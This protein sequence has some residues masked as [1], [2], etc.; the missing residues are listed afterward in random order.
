M[1][2][3]SLKTTLQLSVMI[4]IILIGF[5]ISQFVIQQYSTALLESAKAKAE[6]IAHKLAIDSADLILINDLVSV[7]KELDGQMLTTPSIVYIF[8][9]KEGEVVAH[10]FK[11]GIPR[12]L[13]QFNT[14]F[15]EVNGRIKPIQSETGEKIFDIAWPIFSGR[16][17]TIRLG[18]SEAPY[19]EKVRELWLKMSLITLVIIVLAL[20]ITHYLMN[21]LTKPLSVLTRKVKQ[22]DEGSLDETIEVKGRREVTRL[23]SAFN[24]MLVRLQ[25]HTRQLNRSN[26]ALLNKNQAL[27]RA[28]KQLSKT[29][30][31]SKEVA[32][33]PKLHDISA[34]LLST[35][36]EIL[37]CQQML[38]LIISPDE[39]LYLLSD[40]EKKIL[41]GEKYYQAVQLLTDLRYYR[42]F[43]TDAFSFLDLPV[44]ISTAAKLTV[45]PLQK[46]GELM[47]VLMVGCRE[48]CDC[49]SEELAVVDPILNQTVGAFHRS[50]RMEEELEQLSKKVEKSNQFH[51]LIGKDS[52]MQA[53]FQL[54][55]NVASTDTSVLVQGESGTGKELVAVA[56]HACSPRK[57]K[58]FTVIN[59]SAYPA[60]LLE[61][62]LF[63]HEKGAFTGAS[64]KKAGRF[65]QA[66]GGTV[67]LDEIGEI[68]QS[69][70]IKLLRVLQGRKFERLGG[71][72]T[73]SVDIRILAATN[74]D[75]AMEVQAGNFREDLYYRLN[76]IPI[77]M[78]PLRDRKNDIFLL[79][80]Y[81]L[82]RF[83]DEQNKPVEDFSSEAMHYLKDYF[84]PGNVRELENT[85]EHAVVLAKGRIIDVLDLPSSLTDDR[86]GK[87]GNNATTLS[88]SEEELIRKT[89][90]SCDW[91]KTKAAEIIGISRG[92]LYQKIRKYSIR[93]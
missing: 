73:L 51:G 84:W 45:F 11:N 55:E 61:S 50:L 19:N 91:N 47:G 2:Q 74:K 29:V 38:F 9:E 21:Y 70:Q 37:T 41:S 92:T 87:R 57:N 58:P 53:I 77:N 13:I 24:H 64:R 88:E 18:L 80:K 10:T 4:L 43:P 62:E 35:F 33:L 40:H 89:L 63:G 44:R 36:R 23:T 26:Q 86:S 71:D 12:G 31:I 42:F 25:D 76:V 8:I 69:A 82:N 32:A 75:L 85:I 7:Q 34:Y 66:D 28:Q 90:E 83:A 39:K 56:I 30:A 3:T 60:T 27:E 52:K 46:H 93:N 15:D 16:A 5:I 81:F 59:C 6:N 68:S 49:R 72:Q 65:E 20:I 78:P 54:I 79:A 14:P 1:K 48:R 67:F 17:G 22:I